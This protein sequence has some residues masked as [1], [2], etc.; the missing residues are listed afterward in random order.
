MKIG[1][2]RSAFAPLLG[3]Q[4]I[5]LASWV[6]NGEVSLLLF[7]GWTFAFAAVG[8]VT[9]I[10]S[11][12]DL[13]DVRKVSLAGVF[14]WSFA[15]F[16]LIPLP[17]IIRK[18]IG[19]NGLNPFIFCL[20]TTL[21][22]LVTLGSCLTV[23][24]Y[25]RLSSLVTRSCVPERS[26]QSKNLWALLFAFTALA[27]F[28]LA[29][30]GNLPI[31]KKVSGGT[32]TEIMIARNEALTARSGT[33]LAY[34]FEFTRNFL[35]PVMSA[36]ALLAY[37]RV[38]DFTNGV[39]AITVLSVSFVASVLTLEKSPLIRLMAVCLIALAW[40]ARRVSR[41]AT[42]L[43]I[44]LIG[45]TFLVLVRVGIGNGHTENELG[46]VIDAAWQ[47]VADG[48][49]KIAGDYFAWHAETESAYGLG[50]STSIV[51]RLMDAPA[52]DP[53]SLVYRYADPDAVVQGSANGA[54]FAQ[55][56]VDFGWYGI[57]IGSML[58]G[59]GIA[60]IQHII[61]RVTELS[62]RYA[63]YGLFAVQTAFLVLTAASESIFSVGFGA[64]DLI[65]LTLIW[66]ALNRQR[67]QKLAYKRMPNRWLFS[68]WN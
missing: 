40:E 51:S 42:V 58:V 37:K 41:R 59:A 11:T 18:G 5:Q 32:T 65:V 10:S 3:V 50:R 30:R 62:V 31:L 68:G 28:V 16:V 27:W 8:F 29:V 21:A 25:L 2:A 44:A 57:L 39:L 20:A 47:R 15:V 35:L 64:L 34:V 46:R 55:L 26:S 66:E 13:L 49:T 53:S 36:T 24:Q 67:S 14:A 52:V 33:A 4:L 63:L 7:V 1:F 12:S 6:A 17:S 9:L 22:Y 48:P 45:V 54:Y 43:G 38:R 60:I 61:G 19:N 23:M 56:W